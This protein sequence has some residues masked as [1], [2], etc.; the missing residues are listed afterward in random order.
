MTVKKT[1]TE[2]QH[3]FVINYIKNGFNI[4][5]AALAAGYS[6]SFA[7]VHSHKLIAHPVIKEKIENAY[8]IIESGH[9]RVL[10]MTLYDKA[11]V[12]TDIIEDILNKDEGE[13]KRHLYNVAINAVKELNKMQGDY[14]PDKRLNVTVDAT[15]ERLEEA[16]R[17]YKEF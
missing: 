2:M 4:K 6:E 8:R 10:C 14:A 15:K 3:N 9:N 1:L 13:P 5:Q 16:R 11:K 12:L 17:Q 7:H